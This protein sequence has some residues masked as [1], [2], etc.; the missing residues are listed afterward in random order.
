MAAQNLKPAKNTKPMPQGRHDS[1]QSTNYIHNRYQQTWH[2]IEFS[3]NRHTR[4]HPNHQFRIA[5]EQLFKLT[6]PPTASQIRL[7]AG[8]TSKEPAPP[9][10][11][12][13]QKRTMFQAVIKGGWPLFF[14]FSG[15]DSENNTRPQPPPQIGQGEAALPPKNPGIPGF[16]AANAGPV[17]PVEQ[18]YCFY[19][20]AHIG[21]GPYS[22]R[23]TTS[24]S[25]SCGFRR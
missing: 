2:T 22:T 25:A 15:G 18:H 6:R 20:V 17:T 16:P 1:A 14:R 8:K 19:G 9:I 3:N 11:S 4:H 10:T 23:S 5:P 24:K 21:S 7:P 12:T 13:P